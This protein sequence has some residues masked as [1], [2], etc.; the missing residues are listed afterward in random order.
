MRLGIQEREVRARA[1][2]A[3]RL[4]RRGWAGVEEGIWEMTAHG[5]QEYAMTTKSM[6]LLE[7]EEA[8]ACKALKWARHDSHLSIEEEEVALHPLE[9]IINEGTH[10]V[11]RG[12]A[13]GPIPVENPF[14]DEHAT[15]NK[16][17]TSLGLGIG[18]H[19]KDGSKQDTL[20]SVSPRPALSVD[21]HSL[22]GS[23]PGSRQDS[24]SRRSV[25]HEELSAA[26]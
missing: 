21:T 9:A 13:P 11:P 12:R 1:L 3:F 24:P 26:R 18:S 17:A 8:L 23:R 7:Q 25:F 20:R 15:G 14:G 22:N 4:V 2:K 6:V 10:G 16:S 19:G 5:M